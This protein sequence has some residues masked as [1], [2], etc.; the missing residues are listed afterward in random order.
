MCPS[1]PPDESLTA[2]LGT[3]AAQAQHEL[4]A[5]V[6]QITR[7]QALLADSLGQ[8]RE[9]FTALLALQAGGWAASPHLERA[10]VALQSEDLVSQLLAH[11]SGRM[12]RLTQAVCH[13]H[14]ATHTL[15][16][17]PD[18]KNQREALEATLRKVVY[19]LQ[20]E[21]G[22]GQPVLQQNVTSG[23]VQLF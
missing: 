15:A 21:Q 3:C 4:A 10:I 23:P 17:T 1:P 2:L 11:T 22:Q 16:A 19:L 12:E 18:E 6:E 14:E 9:S 7:A 5:S 20:A 13:L 8:L